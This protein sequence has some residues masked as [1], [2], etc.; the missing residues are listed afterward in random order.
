MRTLLLAACLLLLS[1]PA[2]PDVVPSAWNPIGVQDG[3][4]FG[5]S[6]APAGDVNHDGY[7]D[8]LVGAPGWDQTALD[9]GRVFLYL[10]GPTGLASSPSWAWSPGEEGA[11][12]G[13]CVAGGG[14]VNGDGADD[15]LVGVPNWD[16]PNGFDAGGVFVFLGSV[17]GPGATAWDTLYAG[18]D[19]AHFGTSV[20]T[21]GDVNADLAQDVIVGAPGYS[22]GQ[23]REGGAFVFL[24]APGKFAALPAFTLEANG[25]NARLGFSVSGAG[26]V[27]ADGYA[28][29]IMGAPGFLLGRGRAWVYRGSASG[30][31]ALLLSLAGT[32]DSTQVGYS[33]ANAGD[34]NG[35]GYADVAVGSPGSDDAD[36]RAGRVDVYYGGSAPSALPGFTELGQY[37]DER[38]GSQLATA[39][40]LDGDGYADLLIGRERVPEP[41]S[42]SGTVE[43]LLGGPGGVALTTFLDG[44]HVGIGFAA[45]IATTGDT[46]GDGYAEVI[47]GAPSFEG[48]GAVYEWI[49]RP[50]GVVAAPGSPMFYEAN[51]AFGSAVAIL[52]Q[53]DGDP[54]PAL[55]VGEGLYGPAQGGRAALFHLGSGGGLVPSA[56]QFFDG[57]ATTAFFGS[58]IVDAG[59]VD[60][61]GWTDFL[62]A[63]PNL[64]SPAPAEHGRVWLWR[65][66]STGPVLSPWVGEGTQAFARFGAAI[67]A[68]GDVNGDGYHDVVIA[69]P[70]WD[71]PTAVDC[72]RVQFFPGGPSGL[73]AA[74]WTRAGAVANERFGISV[75][76]AGDLD[77]DGYSDVA[78]GS[79]P[80]SAGNGH[81]EVY[82]GGPAGPSATEGWVLSPSPPEH[83]FSH[84]AAAG[85]W[86]GDGYGDL[87]VGSPSNGGAGTVYLYRGAPGRG[88]PNKPVWTHTE[89]NGEQVG[90]TLAGGGDLNGDGYADAVVAA[91]H[92]ANGE[93]NEGRVLIFY[94]R[95][96]AGGNHVLAPDQAFESNVLNGFLGASLAVGDLDDDGFADI[97]AGAT[98]GSEVFAWYGGGD[99]APF[100]TRTTEP[101]GGV[102]LRF[103]PG[104]LDG[105]TQFGTSQ[106]WRSPA[107]RAR[108]SQQMEVR[109]Q[110]EPFTGIPN[111][112]GP[113]PV[114]TGT[115]ASFGSVIT[116]NFSASAPWK[117]TAS[118]WRRR[119]IT[120]SPY[121]PRSRWTAA[122]GRASAEY[123]FR[124][125]GVVATEPA[126]LASRLEGA[127]PN[128]ARA[129][130]S[131]A[132]TLAADADGRVDVY[133]VGGGHVRTLAR[134]TLAAGR[135][136]LAWDGNDARGRRAPPGVYFVFLRAGAVSDRC[137]VVL[138]P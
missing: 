104:R 89:T 110:G 82:F 6:V 84:V 49:G 70:Y 120:A 125:S 75:A 100:R 5:A 94:G 20:A 137:R 27:N 59:D 8:V 116:E 133:D 64:S 93:Q 96:L 19:D 24:G 122:E 7:G 54:Y 13:T 99:G 1:T 22:N 9:E 67:G 34:V 101:G 3:S 53:V 109:L 38:M 23:A 28:D 97:V 56:I 41:A 78:V 112:N 115:P 124:T 74:T 80:A 17:N 65:G 132:F 105:Q 69:E 95:P 111:R 4:F 127:V 31:G 50:S 102:L 81:V 66:S 103:A 76:L 113:Q 73:G 119:V 77:A 121:F 25:S 10:G 87:L 12:A 43:V 131:I 108:V 36:V 57:P 29:V 135:S 44:P 83:S 79:Y 126:V 16:S 42:E 18:G 45:A 129:G 48:V 85:D 118:R 71:S 134:G 114:D 30:I 72:G 39:G 63:A 61:D 136:T 51:V 90:N 123:D 106:Y 14:D 60:R 88:L 62:I 138:L 11:A 26:D 92:Y 91:T 68:R 52:P 130:T 47:V 58:T 117:A 35:D 32:V 21:A 33:V 37:P 15:I 40:D 98:G 55:A 2:R 128:P 86:D 46:D 107:G